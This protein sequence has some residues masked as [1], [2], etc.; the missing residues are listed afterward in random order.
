MT[1]MI[2]Q[3]HLFD[4]PPFLNPF[5]PT[6]CGPPECLAPRFAAASTLMF[7][8]IFLG[9]VMAFLVVCIRFLEKRLLSE[10]KNH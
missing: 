3:E 7:L 1:R 9:V 6:T 2:A 5:D 10:L 4:D 8:M